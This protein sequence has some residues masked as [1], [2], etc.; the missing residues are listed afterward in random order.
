MSAYYS[1]GVE[2]E[3]EAMVMANLVESSL[4]P[5]D[6]NSFPLI[7]SSGDLMHMEA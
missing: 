2:V 1:S 5:Y 4:M 6:F 3:E 7:V